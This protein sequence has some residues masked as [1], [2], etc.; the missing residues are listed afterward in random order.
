MS[1]GA[2]ANGKVTG[3][4]GPIRSTMSNVRSTMRVEYWGV[5]GDGGICKDYKETGYC[6]YGDSCKFMHDRSDYKQGFHLDKEWERKQKMLEDN[7]K[8]RWEKRLLKKAKLEAD[9]KNPGDEE[10]SSEEEDE[11]SDD[12]LPKECPACESKWE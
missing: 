7:K 3:L 1:E 12:E 9:G 10:S 2:I 8:K 11:D 6:G 4:L 5:S